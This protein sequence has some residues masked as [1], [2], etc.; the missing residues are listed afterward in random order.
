MRLI[1]G[2]TMLPD[3]EPEQANRMLD[4]VIAGL[5]RPAD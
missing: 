3:I 1:G 2:V 5:K 4:I